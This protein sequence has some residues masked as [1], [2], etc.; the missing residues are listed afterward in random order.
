MAEAGDGVAVFFA[1]LR[2][3][4]CEIGELAPGHND[5]LIQLDQAG[6]FQ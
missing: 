4:F 5:I 6:G 3:E 1:Q 2:R